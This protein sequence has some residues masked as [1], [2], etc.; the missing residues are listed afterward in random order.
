MQ[1]YWG[2]NPRK[3]QEPQVNLNWLKRRAASEE[4][5]ETQL[6]NNE[7]GSIL[8]KGLIRQEKEHGLSCRC[9]RFWTF[10]SWIRPKAKGPHSQRTSP[11][12]CLLEHSTVFTFQVVRQH[13]P[14]IWPCVWHI[15]ELKQYCQIGQHNQE[16]LN[17]SFL[18]AQKNH[19]SWNTVIGT[20][21][22]FQGNTR[23]G[24]SPWSTREMT[25]AAG[26]KMIKTLLNLTKLSSLFYPH[27]KFNS[28]QP[29]IISTLFN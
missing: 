6:R 11:K 18:T 17:A 21:Y 20:C 1:K 29:W 12:W 8:T 4:W 9:Q 27:Q 19:N 3:C 25:R 13:A 22:N 15:Q 28:K 23:K 5:L 26:E 24:H 10:F 7:T 14:I 2:G 16:A